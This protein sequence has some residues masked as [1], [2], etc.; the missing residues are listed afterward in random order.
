M[1]IPLLDGHK[2]QPQPAE[3]QVQEVVTAFIVLMSKDGKVYYTPDMATPIL[4]ER[5]PTNEEVT[6]LCYLVQ[7][8]MLAQVTAGTTAN[9]MMNISQ[10][11][12]KAQQDQE[13]LQQVQASSKKG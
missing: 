2:R 7:S 11:V 1:E 6:M 13:I 5:P 4:R 9:T 3:P 8:H 10:A 12:V